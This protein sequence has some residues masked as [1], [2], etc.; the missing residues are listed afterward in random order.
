[1]TYEANESLTA[2]VRLTRIPGIGGA[3]QRSL[4]KRFGSPE[5]VFQTD[6]VGLSEV[7]P[8][9]F[10]QALRSHDCAQDI[11][12]ALRWAEQPGNSILTLADAE[13]PSR[14]LETADPPTLLYAKGN[15][16]LLNSP[17]VAIVGSRN[18]TPQGSRDAE[19]FAG[20]LADA[21]VT[22]ISGLAAGI[23]AAAH[24]GG[25]KGRGS[26]VAVVGTGADRVYPASNHDL[27]QRLASDGLLVSEFPLGTP[28]IGSNF[29][30]RN[31]IISGLSI[32]VLVVEAA[33]RSGSLITARLAA[34]QGRDVFAMPGS[35]HS[36]L[37]KGCHRLIKEGAKLV[38]SAED[39][40]SELG[41]G[42]PSESADTSDPEPDSLLGALGFDPCDI[43]TIAER[44]GLTP[45]L[46]SAML[47]QL[48]LDGQVA[49]LPGGRY[50]RVV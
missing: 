45:E 3:A 21:G 30:R 46:L 26:T 42:A 31:R 39:V 40:L 22:V 44:S 25:L 9:R 38:E 41:L 15:V 17:G 20:A 14:L 23:D 33:M 48:E 35:I 34:E 29:P 18:P 27:A 12:A 10:A 2:W 24:R 5:A 36:P 28:A 50:Q 47:L 1:M 16:G 49:K 7:V 8:Q 6:V 19:S 4:L 13:Y 43:D 37:S 11:D 32:G